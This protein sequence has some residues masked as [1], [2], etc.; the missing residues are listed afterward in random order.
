MTDGY[1]IIKVHLHVYTQNETMHVVGM[2]IECL[3]QFILFSRSAPF[4]VN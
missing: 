1:S 4:A 3:E 2:N